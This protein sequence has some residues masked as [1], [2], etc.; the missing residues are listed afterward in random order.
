MAC[1]IEL[2]ATTATTIAVITCIH[3]AHGFM[4]ASL[5]SS[6]LVIDKLA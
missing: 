1:T 3:R 5:L 2:T 4:T 6:V